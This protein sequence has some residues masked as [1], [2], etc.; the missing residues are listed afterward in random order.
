[1]AVRI[2]RKGTRG[3]KAPEGVLSVTRPG[4]F[5]NPFRI[6]GWFKI[7]RGQG[8]GGFCYLECLMPEYLTPDFVQVRDAAHAVEMFREYTKRYPMKD[9]EIAELRGKDLMCWCPLDEPCHA[10]VLLEIAN[11]DDV[12]KR[13][14][15]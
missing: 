3:W 5:G 14:R 11:S 1:M 4:K 8:T 9:E 2:Q 10:D 12:Y 13:G 7:G 6:G 15:A